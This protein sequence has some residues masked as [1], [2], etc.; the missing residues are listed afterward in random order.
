MMKLGI[1]G[2]GQLGRMLL[3]A[4]GNYT[5]E[6]FVLENDP[7]CPAAHLCHHFTLGDIRDYDTVYAFGKQVEVLTIEIENINID[8]LF[9]LQKEGVKVI[10]R[11][12]P[13]LLLKIK[14]Y[15]NSFMP[16]ITFRLLLFC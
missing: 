6:T 14:A 8:A 9:Q 10:H 12:K 1:L 5:L 2:G 4:A 16:I 15:K 11:L 13:L 3:Q 7:T